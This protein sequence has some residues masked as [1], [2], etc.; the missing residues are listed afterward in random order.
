MLH[1]IDFPNWHLGQFNCFNFFSFQIEL[2]LTRYNGGGKGPLLLGHGLGVAS[3]LF[4]FDTVETNFLD[5][6]IEHNYDVWLFDWRA[7]ILLPWACYTQYTLD[8]VANYDWKVGTDKIL[9]VTGKV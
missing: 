6:V 5:Y 8:D 3:N 2:R 1:N 4:T 9:E 7:S